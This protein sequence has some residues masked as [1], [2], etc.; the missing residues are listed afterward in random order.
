MMTKGS[1][2]WLIFK[3]IC[4]DYIQQD[5]C[6]SSG[7]SFVFF[8]FRSIVY[9]QHSW[10]DLSMG[11]SFCSNNEQIDRHIYACWTMRRTKRRKNIKRKENAR[12]CA[13]V[14]VGW[15]IFNGLGFLFFLLTSNNRDLPELVNWNDIEQKAKEIV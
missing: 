9:F 1:F 10:C 5:I 4:L 7:Q 15:I 6:H 3:A 11:S 14:L 8:S 2:N 13:T 12:C